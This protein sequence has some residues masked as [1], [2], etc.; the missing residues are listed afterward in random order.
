MSRL[1]IGQVYNYVHYVVMQRRSG[2]ESRCRR[3]CA[4]APGLVFVRVRSGGSEGRV[5]DER[6]DATGSMT[7]LVLRICISID[8]RLFKL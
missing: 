4:P 7:R 6:S 2:K 1:E 8:W 3:E 5:G